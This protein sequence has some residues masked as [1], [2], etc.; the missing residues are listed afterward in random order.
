MA[1]EYQEYEAVASLLDR[2]RSSW[3]AANIVGGILLY[4]SVLLVVI[5]M[6]V[7]VECFLADSPI[8][9]RRALGGTV[10]GVTVLGLA[11]FVLWR[12]LQDRSDEEFALL[13]EREFPEIDN[14]LINAVRLAQDE[15][16]S[17]PA[18][19]AAGMRETL[20]R[21]QAIEA[22][23]AVNRRHVKRY[24]VSAAA[25]AALALALAVFVPGRIANAIQRIFKPQA[26][27]AKIGDVK[28]LGVA[29]G[30]CTGDNALVAGETLTVTVTVEPLGFRDVDA[31]LSY[32]EENES[33]LKEHRLRMVDD[34]SFRGEIREVKVPL[35]Y[36]ARVGDSSTRFFE[37]EVVEPPS[38]TGIEVDYQYPAYTG[39]PPKIEKDSDGT[40]RGVV[41]TYFGMRVRSNRPLRKSWLRLDHEEDVAMTPT[42]GGSGAFLPQRMKIERDRVYTL[43][44]VD[45]RGYEN[46]EPVQRNIRALVDGKPTVKIAQPGKDTVVAPGDRLPVVVRADDDYG[47]SK[48]ALVG[49]L[50]RGN[51][52]SKDAL[53]HQWQQIPDGKKIVL[54]WDWFFDKKNYLSGDIMRYYVVVEDNNNVS[55]PGVG[56]SS[57]FEV[58]V[59]DP[60]T[61]KKERV[62]KYEN[63]QA[64]LEKVLNDQVRL[65]ESTTTLEK[66]AGEKPRKKPA[67][68]E[69][70]AQP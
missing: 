22:T 62:E 29:P 31:D 20:Q 2:V 5:L 39:E 49:R 57:E 7:G 69:K 53:I 27:L 41:G 34:T 66:L 14:G 63:W 50:R 1:R 64:E 42:I 18:L 17:S 51:E 52:E 9:L 10:A 21:A 35:E 68:P 55:G 56:K 12:I 45:E 13:V 48:V 26:N 4:T 46:R 25:L 59:R 11:I 54:T 43:H 3:R 38:I 15:M 33:I 19:V 8:W 60:E 65:R 61:V 16:V 6:A 36:Q 47:F 23:R 40:I 70:A 58:R 67:E 32:R 28:I 30:D 44:I 24:G 37:V